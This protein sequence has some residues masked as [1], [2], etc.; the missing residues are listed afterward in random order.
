MPISDKLAREL[1]QEVV[2]ELAIL[3]DRAIRAEGKT[4]H[5]AERILELQEEI[6]KLRVTREELI[7][8]ANDLMNRATADVHAIED[9]LRHILALQAG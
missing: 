5:Q 8:M 6:E 2:N 9:K 4:G 1:P 7:E 3:E